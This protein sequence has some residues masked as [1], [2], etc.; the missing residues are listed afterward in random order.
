MQALTLENVKISD[1]AQATL[2][3]QG[4]PYSLEEYPMFKAIFNSGSNRRLL[5]AGRQ[6]SKTMTFAADIL[7]RAILTP[8][9]P[10]IYAN[11]SAAQTTS[12]STS[13]LDP[14]LAHSPVVHNCLM[15]T[16]NVINNV[17]NKRFD[18]FAEVRL[19]YFSESADRVRGNTGFMFYVD[20]VQDMLYDALIDAEE[21]LSA[22]PHPKFMYAGT[23]K[24][25]ITP[26]EY[27]WGMSTKREWLIQC[28]SCNKHNVPSLE[29]I[30][31]KGLICKACGAALNTYEGFWHRFGEEGAEYD[32]FRIPQIILPLHCCREEKWANLL[33]KLENYPDYKIRNEIMGDPLGEGESIITED[34]LKGMC[35]EEMPMAVE[36]EPNACGG[37]T[38]IAGG[39]DWGGGGTTGTSRTVLTIYAVNSTKPEYRMVFGKIYESGEPTKHLEDIAYWLRMFQV[40]HTYADHGGGNFAISQLNSLMPGMAIVPV[41]YTDQ[42]AP[43]KWDKA[44]RRFTVNRTNMIDNFIGDIK[45][46]HVRTFRWD[47]FKPF[48]K[49]FLN[50]KEEVIGDDRGV[51]RR[52]WRRFPSAPDDSL[53]A[54]LYGWLASRILSGD[55]E[56]TAA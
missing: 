17:F 9:Y 31:K 1:V 13:K 26:L 10:M 19:T 35:R 48:A 37:A 27:F 22:A 42:A 24:S 5:K 46:R 14:F 28:S 2:L 11:T 53:H 3:F 25:M 45:K 51:G 12:F 30:G 21:C 47:E 40:T 50:V 8:Y 36:K 32:G 23:S 49:D 34:L 38:Y 29:N 4:V 33:K 54:M 18:N 43:L 39:I 15:R 16:K 55:T 20:E 52:V 56:F 7:S 6:V 41:M 44:A